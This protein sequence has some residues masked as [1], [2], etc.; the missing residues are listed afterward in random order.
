MGAKKKLNVN[1]HKV[2]FCSKG[3]HLQEYTISTGEALPG[4]GIVL[5]LCN[6]DRKATCFL[7]QMK[8]LGHAGCKCKVNFGTKMILPT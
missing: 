3:P 8:Q 6:S 4:R 1:I 5:C 7:A 2:I